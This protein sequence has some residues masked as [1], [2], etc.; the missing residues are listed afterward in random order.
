MAPRKSSKNIIRIRDGIRSY[1]RD[2]DISLIAT[3]VALS[4]FSLINIYGLSKTLG[5]NYFSKQ[6]IYELVGVFLMVLFSFFNYRYLKNYSLP[7]LIVYLFTVFLLGL[8]FL[9]STIRNVKSWIV[10]GGFTFEPSELA[11]L[12]IIVVMSKYFSQRHIHI[13]QFRHTIVAGVYL[14][15]PLLIIVAQPDLGS[16]II[17]SLI[18]FGMLAAAGISKKHLAI[19]LFFAAAVAGISW[20]AVLRPY[21]KERIVSF[22][23]PYN[24]PR[25]S[26]Y[27]LIQSQIAIGSGH[28]FG[29]GFGKG[30]QTNL[31]FL[32]EPHNDFVFASIAE[33]FGIFGVGLCL[34]AILFLVYRILEIGRVTTSNFGKLFSV[35]MALFIFLHAFVGAGV[36]IGL[37]PVTGLPFP[38][39]SYGGSHYVALMVGLGILQSIKRYG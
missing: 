24:D 27:N 16:A 32:P 39:L 25:G 15:V 38:F 6:I 28:I 19:L 35:G 22:L 30:T 11:K 4:L 1:L 8:T 3:A 13:N 23:N 7:V 20:F 10:L 26:D 37:M 29:K 14:S 18:W 33:Q 31:G 36:N 2:V 21:Q 5:V 12:M 9:S 17:I 34:A